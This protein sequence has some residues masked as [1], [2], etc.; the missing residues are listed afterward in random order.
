[1]LKNE[2]VILH[3]WGLRGQN[4]KELAALL[5]KDGHKVYLLDLPG[6]GSQP[7]VNDNMIL[8]DYVVFLKKFLGKNKVKKP[9]LI[10]HSFGGRVAIK[11]A[12]RYKNAAEALILTGVPVIRHA[13]LKRKIAYFTAVAGGIVFKI[14]PKET[15]VFMRKVLYSIIGE[16]DY[17]KAGP[18]QQ[19]FKNIIGEELTAYIKN[20]SVP[21]MLVWGKEDRIVSAADA[22]Q[23][24]KYI[25]HAKV[26]IVAGEGHK[27]P[28]ISPK[29][30][31]KAIQ[32]VL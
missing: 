32:S 22:W 7:L 27:L 12:W 1:M 18:L 5:K 3:G 2:I 17:Y 4:Y 25:L 28:Y 14:F 19:V 23:I 9:I 13:S 21:V 31:V 24:K 30:F 15:K 11:Y 29:N 8:D 10:G 6:F 26:V 20:I 16:W